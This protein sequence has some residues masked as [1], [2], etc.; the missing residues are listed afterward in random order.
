M[1]RRYSNYWNPKMILYLE[2]THCMFGTLLWPYY[3]ISLILQRAIYLPFRVTVD[4]YT[5]TLQSCK[6]NWWL[7]MILSFCDFLSQTALTGWFTSN[8]FICTRLTVLD[9]IPLGQTFDLAFVLPVFVLFCTSLRKMLVEIKV[10][11][12]YIA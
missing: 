7:N 8:N 12:G 3:S 10:R 1:F 6:G 2:I 11:L 9:T 5:L 4:R